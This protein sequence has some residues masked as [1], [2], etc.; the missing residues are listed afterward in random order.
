M[1]LFRHESATT[2]TL[3][4]YPELQRKIF[5]LYDFASRWTDFDPIYND[6]LISSMIRHIFNYLSPK[7]YRTTYI[8]R[9]PDYVAVVV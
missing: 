9:R 2:T 3:I 4:S 7:S 8:I 5:V 6:F 1:N